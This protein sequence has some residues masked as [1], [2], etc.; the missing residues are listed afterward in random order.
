MLDLFYHVAALAVVKSS[1]GLCTMLPGIQL[2]AFYG[3]CQRKGVTSCG[4]RYFVL[5]FNAPVPTCTKAI[6]RET[7]LV[8]TISGI[9]LP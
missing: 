7:L 3:T 4:C 2:T 8:R 1:H 9:G 6:V 5:S